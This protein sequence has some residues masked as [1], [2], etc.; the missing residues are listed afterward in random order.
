[1]ATAKKNPAAKKKSTAKKATRKKTTTKKKPAAKKNA[2]FLEQHGIAEATLDSLQANVFIA[3]TDFTLV[4]I[5]PK[6]YA[7][8]RSFEQDVEE[9][10][11]LGVDALRGGSIHRFHRSPKA[12]ER[13][14]KNPAALPHQ[15]VFSFGKTTLR[16]HINAL[17]D[18]HG[19]LGGYV[20]NWEDVSEEILRQ[21]EIDRVTAMVEN[22][23]TAV[24]LADLDM[25][26]RYVNPATRKM[27]RPLEAHMACKVDELVGQSI[28]IFH[29]RP[30]HQRNILRD[31]KNLPYGAQIEIGAEKIDL[32]ASAVYDSNG[33]YISV[34]VTWRV[35]TE[36]LRV[37]N[38]TREV[39]Q[40]LAASSQE[41]TSVSQ[42]MSSAAEE[43]AAQ[44]NQV[45]A[46]SQQVTDSLQSVSSGTEE[47]T[48]SIKEIASNALD[49]AKVADSAVR[50]AG[51]TRDTIDRLGESSAQIG[52]VIK[53]ITGV[54]QQTK[55]LALNATIEAA[56]AGEAGKGFAVV[57]NEVKELAKETA[58]ATEDIGRKIEA[59]QSDTNGAVQAISEISDVIARINEI[60]NSIA[61]AV[62]EQTITTAD[63]SRTLGD[64]SRNSEEIAKNIGNVADA[65]KQVANG[66]GSTLSSAGDLQNLAAE[67]ETLIQRQEDK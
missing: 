10:F 7:S 3:D 51:S 40:T 23:P 28:D 16:S 61:S 17:Y 58:K 46:A 42:E 20:V 44:A 32:S 34:M 30:E 19:E 36:E 62:E 33:A 66:A 27:L 37:E 52:E 25:T 59:I 45:S 6:A 60:Q 48:A 56:R 13:I 41:L 35:I 14:L 65:A 64:A 4:Y 43:T 15:A 5:N 12:V 54:A 1:M 67:L 39:S 26:I 2:S 49:A 18:D 53:V 11:G 31:D 50:V 21:A 57:A 29:K 24:V 9:A 63:I 8:L 55:M 22:S 47:L 38:K